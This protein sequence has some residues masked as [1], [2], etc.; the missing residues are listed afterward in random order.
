MERGVII[1][2]PDT[3]SL[4]KSSTE[5]L[6]KD[7][8]KKILEWT[9][10]MELVMNIDAGHILPKLMVDEGNIDGS[11]L[12]LS[13]FVLVDF[14]ESIGREVTYEELQPLTIKV[15]QDILEPHLEVIERHFEEERRKKESVDEE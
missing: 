2:T 5:G 15:L 13:T 1:E 14:F 4:E 8:R 12:Q 10:R 11:V 7:V 9:T 6:P 3:T